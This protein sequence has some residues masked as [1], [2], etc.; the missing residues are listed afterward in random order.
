MNSKLT[1]AVLLAVSVAIS[2]AACSQDT[3]Q[4]NLDHENSQASSEATEAPLDTAET[5]LTNVI[6]AEETSL[7]TQKETNMPST[8]TALM[9]TSKG[10]ITIELNAEKAPISVANFISYAEAGHYDG[11]LFHRV[12]PGFMIQGGGFEPGMKQK[13]TN[14]PIDNEANNGLSNETYTLA[15]ARTNAPNSATSQFF[16]NVVDNDRLDFTSESGAGWGYAVFAKVT[17]GQD[18]VKE[19]EAVNTGQV[20]PYGDVPIEDVLIESVTIVD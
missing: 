5:N 11:T 14:T 16:I 19:I 12:I 20:G 3:P 9:K 6:S 4:K 13:P 1:K 7:T 18:V 15:M 10:E 8:R 2:V 17:D